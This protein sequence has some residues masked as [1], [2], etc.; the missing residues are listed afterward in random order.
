MTQSRISKAIILKHR[1]KSMARLEVVIFRLQ[2]KNPG[3]CPGFCFS[4]LDARFL[5]QD[6]LRAFARG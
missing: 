1:E 2:T 6:A 5:M 3:F 4:V